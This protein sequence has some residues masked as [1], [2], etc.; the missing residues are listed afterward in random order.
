MRWRGPFADSYF[1]AAALV[2]FALVPYL[3]LASA[4]Q[5]LQTQIATGLHLSSQTLANTSG[6]AN[7][8]YAFGTVLAVQLAVRTRPRRLL[9]LYAAGLV[10]GSVMTALAEPPALFIAGHIL[11]GLF[12]SL[13]LIAAVPPL[14]IGWPAKRM[15]ITAGIMNLCIFGAVAAGPVIGQ[16]QL[17]AHAWRPLF[18]LAT[19]SAVLALIFVILTWEDESAPQPRGSWDPMSLLLAGGG[20]AVAFFGASELTSHPFLSTITFLPLVAGVSAVVLLVIHQATISDPLMPMRQLITT[21]PTAGILAAMAAGASSVPAID[22]VE[23]AIKPSGSPAHLGSLFWPFFGGAVVMAVVFGLVLKTRGLIVLVLIGLTVLAGGVATLTGAA[24]GPHTLVAFGSGMVG[25]GVG[26]SVAPALFMAGYSVRAMY[27]Q[28]V[29]ALVELLRAVAA[30]LTAPILLHLALSTGGITGAGTETA[31]WI[32]FGLA[33]G[34]ALLSLYVLI[35]GRARPQAPDIERWQREGDVP[36]W[37]SPPL[38][39]GIRSP[40]SRRGSAHYLPNG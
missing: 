18:W 10:I 15:P 12:T 2:I 25:V 29:L 38:A 33:A 26:S 21:K 6:L 1:A 20:S 4:F 9:A 8:G 17:S 24:H 31:L 7:A 30:F 40:K 32:C 34:G 37:D 13:M 39:A 28:R 5:P 36:A 3:A 35:L 16:M 14:V 22:L 23:Q 11:Q 19:G 27:I